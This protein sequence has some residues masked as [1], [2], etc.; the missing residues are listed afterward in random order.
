MIVNKRNSLFKRE[1]Q[2]EKMDDFSKAIAL[3]FYQKS[4]P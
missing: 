4:T 3:L 2:I 1:K